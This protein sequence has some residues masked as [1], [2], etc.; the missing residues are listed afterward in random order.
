MID[1]ASGGFRSLVESIE[2]WAEKKPDDAAF[3]L[4]GDGE[5][6]TDRVSFGRLRA[7]ARGSAAQ[8]VDR[9]L[10]G[11]PVLIS[12]E[13]K[14]GF[15]IAFCAC[16][17]SGAI[18]VPAPLQTRN[19]GLE[20]LRAIAAHAGL[21]AVVSPAETAALTADEVLGRL[22]WLGLEETD[23]AEN[24]QVGM[25]MSE[26]PA[27]LQYTSGSTGAP[28]AVMLSQ[29][30]LVANLEMIRSA[31]AIGADSVL[32]TWLPLFHDM[33]F[34]NVLMTL[35]AGI[36]C[37]L[38]PPLAFLQRPE[39][40]LQAISRYRATISGGPNFA[41]D[42]CAARLDRQKFHGIDL[43]S[44]RA[45]LCGSEPVRAS[46]MQRFA[47]ACSAYGFRPSALFPCYGM[48]E[49]SVFVSGGPIDSGIKTTASDP[50]TTTAWVS[51]GRPAPDSCVVIVDLDTGL[52]L[53][54]GETGEIWL[55]GDHVASGYWNDPTATARTFGGRLPSR[56]EQSFLRTGDLGFFSQRELYVVGRRSGLIIHRGVNLHPD[57]IEATVASSHPAFGDIGAAFSIEI[58][59]E[60]QVV[61]V[62]EVSRVDLNSLDPAPMVDHAIDA[63]AA[64]FGVRLFDLVLVRPG[65]IPRKTRDGLFGEIRVGVRHHEVCSVLRHL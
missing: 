18:A 17:Y 61:V 44:W 8:L 33:G 35:H 40:W 47:T 49:A 37:V 63:L 42:R 38:M 24:D 45:A 54:E 36:A 27:L 7:R 15:I 29:Q 34:V 65:A 19:R 58:D 25:N 32:L 41:F 1:G 9:N 62:Y 51:C 16:L 20:R 60:E 13:T 10:A 23:E 6:E 3:V 14:L 4:L 2:M 59:A 43:T 48:A 39:R 56:P 64:Q 55:A 30:N 53:P 5:Q 22:P 26:G 31:V 12:A 28:K 52:E 21:A 46:T 11:K 57:D 50:Q